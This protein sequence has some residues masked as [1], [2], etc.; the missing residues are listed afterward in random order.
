MGEVSDRVR[1]GG[2]DVCVV[3]N[4]ENVVLGLHRARHLDADPARRVEDGMIRAPSTF[5]PNV[6]IEKVAKYM[7]EH[8]LD[9]APIT[10]SDGRLVG[11]LR[12]EDAER[13][14]R[15]LQG[16]SAEAA[17]PSQDVG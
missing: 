17:E 6:P 9:A 1:G 14:V 8:D 7:R 13:V 4:E 5:R 16:D 12:L 15:E 11:L 10:T 2:W 3:V